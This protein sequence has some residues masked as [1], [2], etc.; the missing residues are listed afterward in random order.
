MPGTVALYMVRG[1][2]VFEFTMPV[3]A[4]NATIQNLRLS[5]DTDS[6][7]L[8]IPAVSIYNWQKNEW[9]NLDGVDQGENLISNA[10]DL[11]SSEGLVQIRI[12]AENA[13][14]CYYVGLGMEG[15]RP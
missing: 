3:E 1:E 13:Q 6:G 14:A 5:L 8:N 9:I 15:V 4:S 10:A 11:V 2:A 12:T 7:W